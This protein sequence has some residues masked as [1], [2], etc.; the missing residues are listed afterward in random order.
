M[1][2]I[3]ERLE[4]IKFNIGTL[5]QPQKVNIVAI[6]K[7]FSYSHIKPLVDHGHTHFGENKVQ[8]TLNKWVEIKKESSSN[9]ITTQP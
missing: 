9:D 7:T 6:S 4:K 2:T 3:V 1:N 5:K 8:E